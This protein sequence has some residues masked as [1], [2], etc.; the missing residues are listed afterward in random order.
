MNMTVD[1]TRIRTR[2]DLHRVFSE[3]LSLPESYG[4]NLDALHDV[5]TSIN[6]TI[7]LKG[8]NEAREALGRYGNVA[9]KVLSAAALE[10]E[11]LDVIY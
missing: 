11:K 3:A 6:G 5:L 1:C 2:E 10:N 8:W 9:E 7:R 4:K